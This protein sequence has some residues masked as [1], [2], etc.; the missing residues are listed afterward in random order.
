MASDLLFHLRSLSR[1]IYVVTEEEDRFLLSLKDTL[2]SKYTPR[3]KVFNAALGLVPL[4]QLTRDWTNRKHEEGDP[5]PAQIHDALI[6]MYKDDPK[7]E[8][9]FYVITDPERWLGDPHV[10]RR[11]LNIVHQLHNDIR[12]IKILIFVGTRKAIPEKLAPYMEVVEDKGLTKDHVEKIVGEA[13]EHL[14]LPMP[15]DA[16]AMFK[17]LTD[18]QCNAAI[19]Q[20]VAHMKREDVPPKERRL[21]ADYIAEY[22]RQQ[23]SKTDL[24]QHVDTAGFTFAKVGGMHRFKDWAR[25][26]KAAWTPEGRAFGLEPP[27]GVLAVGVWGC[28]KSLSMKALAAEWELPLIQLETGNLRKS[29]VGDTEARTYR[30]LRIIEAAAPCLVWIDEAEKSLSGGASSAQS[31]AG[32]TSRMI[33]IL[34]TWMQETDAPVCMAMTANTLSTMPVEFVN[35]M[36]ERWYFM[37]PEV[38]DRIDILK[39]HL[40][41]RGQDPEKFPL[42][43][44]SEKA[45]NL[46]GREIEQVIK[47]AFVES[48]AQDKDGLDSDILADLLGRKPRIVKT[49]TDEIAEVV[50]WVGYDADSDDGIKARYASDPNKKRGGGGGPKVVSTA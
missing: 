12:T 45:E 10:Q 3:C 9:N 36:D 49:M 11:I 29:G 21:Q 44:L 22:R 24:V 14:K 28:G 39:I 34:S 27:K 20:S 40:S 48:F 2:K 25:K 5:G 17:G 31:D 38:D 43:M 50:D 42:A 30:A 18:W 4:D 47:A 35:R 16:H 15:E 46:V 26:T 1:L 7:D 37:Q 8:Q 41:A 6:Q 19:A 32:T 13:C 23:I 33:G